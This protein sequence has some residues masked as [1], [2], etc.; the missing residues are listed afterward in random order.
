MSQPDLPAIPVQDADRTSMYVKVVTAATS[1]Q[2]ERNKK[3][4]L[5]VVAPHVVLS[6][7]LYR[8]HRKGLFEVMECHLI[9]PLPLNA[10]LNI[11]ISTILLLIHIW[12]FD[13]GLTPAFSGDADK[14][15]AI[16]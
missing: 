3:A 8:I 7:E 12:I 10:L 11:G 14:L 9:R 16:R 5:R 15:S 13:D 4:P 6:N 1:H 2:A